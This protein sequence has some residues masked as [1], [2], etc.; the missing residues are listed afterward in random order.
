MDTL[1]SQILRDYTWALDELIDR[2]LLI[3]S[4]LLVPFVGH[5][6]TV[7]SWSAGAHLSYLF[8]EFP[9]LESYC[10]ILDRRDFCFCFGDGGLVQIRYDIEEGAIVNH[11]LCYFPCPFSFVRQDS[12]G[13]ALS[14]LPLL[15]SADELRW[16]IKLASPIR[17][18]FDA[19]LS[20]DRHAHS[21]VSLNKD[22]CRIP[23]Y[24]PISLGHFLRFV[25]RYFY[26]EEFS[27][28]NQ[29]EELRPRLYRRTL[30]HPPPH[31]LHFDTAA[32]YF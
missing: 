22:S 29:L 20:D 21:H 12:E 11:R 10:A 23:A 30:L 3:D 25:L 5:E 9:A 18:D 16:R 17:F 8:G 6:R 24:G 7:L 26:E 13:I 28:L 31:E 27:T 2:E 15:F 32:E 4:N 14:E 1:A 19:E